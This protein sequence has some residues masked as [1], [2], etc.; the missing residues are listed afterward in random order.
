MKFIINRC[1]ILSWVIVHR[2]KFTRGRSS[3]GLPF[4]MNI[5]YINLAFSSCSCRNLSSGINA[6]IYR[7]FLRGVDWKLR[8]PL[9]WFWYPEYSIMIAVVS[10]PDNYSVCMFAKSVN[11][12]KVYLIGV[13]YPEIRQ[14]EWFHIFFLF[15]FSISC[16]P[17]NIKLHSIEWLWNVTNFSLSQRFYSCSSAF[18]F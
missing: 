8:F 3:R 5:S 11:I 16:I 9:E 17:L 2:V 6:F 4:T 12:L 13:F 18:C 1:I 10:K 14:Y 15:S 7:W